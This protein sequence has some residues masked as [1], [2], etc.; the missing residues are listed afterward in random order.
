MHFHCEAKSAANRLSIAVRA[1]L[2]LALAIGA[3]SAIFSSAIFSSAIFSG[4]RLSYTPFLND[5]AQIEKG[6]AATDSA[7]ADLQKSDDA[8]DANLRPEARKSDYSLR[9]RPRRAKGIMLSSNRSILERQ[10]ESQQ[11]GFDSAAAGFLITGGLN[12]W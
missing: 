9:A 7:D 2:A 12:S 1:V 5:D 8:T 3:S 11:G 4:S 6:G 10:F